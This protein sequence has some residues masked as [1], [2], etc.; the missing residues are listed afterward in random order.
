MRWV[1]R[2]IGLLSTVVL[3][4]LLVPEDFGL[5]AMAALVLGLVDIL[6]D[7]GVNVALIRNPSPEQ[8]DYDSAWT[9]RM[10]QMGVAAAVVVLA[11]PF[12]ADYFREPRVAEVLRWLALSLLIGAAENIGIV[13]F[14]KEMRF[15]LDFRFMFVKRVFG[16]LVTV[17]AAWHLRSYWALIV[18][19]LATRSCGVVLSYCMHPM[20]PRVS[21]DRA[22]RIMSVSQWLLARSVVNYFAN[23]MD[24]MVVGRSFDAS[25]LGAYSI[26]S[27]VAAMPATE[28]LSPLNRV[29][30]PAFVRVQHDP[31]EFRRLY[32]LSQGVQALLAFPACIGL[33]MVAEDAVRILLGDRWLSAVPIIQV[34]VLGK[35][36]EAVTTSGSYVLLT[37]GRVRQSTIP[38]A[39]QV[40]AFLLL[41]GILFP[42]PGLP[43]VAAIRVAVATLALVVNIALVKQ[44]M[45]GLRVMDVW[46]TTWRPLCSV[47][48][49]AAVVAYVGRPNEFNPL[50]ALFMKAAV[51]GAVYVTVTLL[52]WVAAGKPRGAESYLAGRFTPRWM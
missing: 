47:V 34:L 7:L 11:A 51:G 23:K 32:L 42:E 9:L 50:A 52:L 13:T 35:L 1:D 4:R 5:V 16:F 27:E 31:V 38:T 48:A 33:A 10:L 45:A 22:G 40:L 37:V 14:Q 8:A 18:G 21:L 41:V 26:G 24:V 29:L 2:F 36:V 3:A 12:A 46:R 43:E 19:M 30:F 28:L 25:V 15:G 44:A 20:R 17:A 6:L 49:M 39:V